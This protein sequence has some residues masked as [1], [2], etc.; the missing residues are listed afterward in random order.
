M[1]PAQLRRADWSAHNNSKIKRA[2]KIGDDGEAG[3][4]ERTY[5]E[6]ILAARNLD[7]ILAV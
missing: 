1:Y 4:G 6:H 5:F 2:A 3:G 7:D